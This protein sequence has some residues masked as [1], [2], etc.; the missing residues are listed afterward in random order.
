MS[1]PST[2]KGPSQVPPRWAMKLFTRVHIF[3]YRASGGR[4]LNRL[5]GDLICMV[6]MTGAKSG[7]KRTFPLM[8]VPHENGVILVASL[9]GAPKNPIWYNNLVAHPDI[10]V[11]QGGRRM[12]LRARQVDAEEKAKLWPICV[13]N[14]APYEDYQQRTD[15]DI[16]VFNC[17]PRI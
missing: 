2:A 12:L 3:L 4:L 17:Q 9:G 13:H 10:E 15:R 1:E 7:K 5:S 16:P 6:R 8:Y 11:E 14:Y